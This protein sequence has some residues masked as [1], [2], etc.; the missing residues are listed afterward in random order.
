MDQVRPGPPIFH[1]DGSW[2]SLQKGKR[3]HMAKSKSN[4]RQAAEALA[5][6]ALTY[7]GQDP[8]RLGRFLSLS[9]LGPQSL[10]TAAQETG[11]LAGVLDHIASDE[12]LLVDFATQAGFAPTD[13]DRARRVLGSGDWEP[14][15]P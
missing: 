2:Y 5:V 12:R 10:R 4:P 3:S 11:F 6:Q 7:L 15:M 8:E 1:L 14:D 13:I 9:G